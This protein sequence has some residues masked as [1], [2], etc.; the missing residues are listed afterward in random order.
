MNDRGESQNNNY[1]WRGGDWRWHMGTF[2]GPVN[3]LH[4]AL[5]GDYMGAYTYRI[6]SFLYFTHFIICKLYFNKVLKSD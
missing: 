1:F 6:V 5:C 4:L 2:W 3:I